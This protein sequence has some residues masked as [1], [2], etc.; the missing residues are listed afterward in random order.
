MNGITLRT[1]KTYVIT[2]ELIED[3]RS[4]NNFIARKSFKETLKNNDPH[5]VFF[6]EEKTGIS[7]NEYNRNGANVE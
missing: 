6:F 5:L 3:L 7:L 1:N 4:E 2:N